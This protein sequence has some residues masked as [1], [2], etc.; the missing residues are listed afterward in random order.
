MN[1]HYYFGACVFAIV[2]VYIIEALGADVKTLLLVGLAFLFSLMGAILNELYEHRI[3]SGQF[4][5]N[6]RSRLEE[7]SFELQILRD[8]K[9]NELQTRACGLMQ[10]LEAL[11]KLVD[12]MK[13]T[14]PKESADMQPENEPQGNATT[15]LKN[16]KR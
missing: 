15:H 8:C 5:R 2:F 16:V 6:V 13:Q 14:N 12:H 7:T 4:E 10:T 11:D 1:K 3:A 9:F